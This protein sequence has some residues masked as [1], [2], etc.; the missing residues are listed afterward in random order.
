[1]KPASEIVA[2]DVLAFPG[3]RNRHALESLLA[4]SGERPTV[5][6]KRNSSEISFQLEP[7]ENFL[8]P[9]R[10]SQAKSGQ[11]TP[12]GL[13]AYHWNLGAMLAEV[14]RHCKQQRAGAGHD[15]A[16]AANRQTGLDH[17]LQT[18]RAHHIRQSPSGKREKSFPRS[19]CQH[20][21]LVGEFAE[22]IE[23]F[24]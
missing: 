4:M 12:G 3:A 14:G 18:T 6:G 8:R 10:Q 16:L 22:A 11:L 24:R 19:G 5:C 13:L 23:I 7:L 1:M 9:D 2:V 17:R 15:N 21:L 20:Q